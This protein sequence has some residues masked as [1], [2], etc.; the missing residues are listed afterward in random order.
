MEPSSLLL[1]HRAL[2][3]FA[4]LFRRRMLVSDDTITLSY[5]LR[6][7]KRRPDKIDF[8][9]FIEHTPNETRSMSIFLKIDSIILFI[10][11]QR[12]I[13]FFITSQFSNIL[14]FLNSI[15]SKAMPWTNLFYTKLY[16]RLYILFD[17]TLCFIL[18]LD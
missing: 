12:I 10:F 17:R 1:S 6:V 4:R 18:N 11:P 8:D 15:F 13:F 5:E 2:S 3:E 9:K 7:N 14:E 16:T